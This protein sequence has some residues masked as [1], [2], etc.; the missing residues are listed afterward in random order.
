LALLERAINYNKILI[1]E[2]FELLFMQGI[3]IFLAFRGFGFASFIWALLLSRFFSAIVFFF[4]RPWRLGFRFSYR[5]LSSYFSFGYSY[6]ITAIVS[7][8][9]GAFI[10]LVIGGFV[11][12][13]AAGLLNWAAGVAAV[14]RVFSDILSRLIF[15]LCANIR[16]DRKLLQTVIE[17]ALFAAT[18]FSYPAIAML[19]VL[20]KPVTYIVFTDK[21]KDGISSLFVFSLATAMMLVSELLTQILFALGKEKIA[22]NINILWMSIVWILGTIFVYFTGFIGYPIAWLFGSMIVV[23]SFWQVKKIVHIKNLADIVTNAVLSFITGIF[24]WY[25]LQR[26]SITNILEL[27]AIGSG[28]FLFYLILS[29]IFQGRKLFD[30]AKSLIAILNT[31]PI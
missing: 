1:A 22:K 15:P 21:W 27:I 2:V 18:F 31:K 28:G 12:T 20:S 16:H 7:M 17:H 25:I 8:L 24:I 19:I 9:S 13:T 5:D 3:T 14:P 26:L 10:P 6:Q 30:I 11:G 23:L 29:V 4:L